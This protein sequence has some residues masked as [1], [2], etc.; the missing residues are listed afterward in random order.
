M[1]YNLNILERTFLMSGKW[2]GFIDDLKH[3]QNA[4]I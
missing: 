1:E 4:Y 3:Y 2:I